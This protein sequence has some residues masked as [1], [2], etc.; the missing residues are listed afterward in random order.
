MTKRLLF[1]EIKSKDY[2]NMMWNVE[3]EKFVFPEFLQDFL[4][5]TIWRKRE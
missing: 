3:H 4:H 5:N 2:E 1:F